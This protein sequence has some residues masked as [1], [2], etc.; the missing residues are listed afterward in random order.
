MGRRR[1]VVAAMV[2]KLAAELVMAS[3]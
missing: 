1:E 3:F 2:G